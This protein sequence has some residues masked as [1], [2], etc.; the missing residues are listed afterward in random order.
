M[1]EK[2]C[3]IQLP[4]SVSAD[5]IGLPTSGA[6]IDQAIFMR[7]GE[8]YPDLP[9]GQPGPVAKTDHFCLYGSIHPFDPTAQDIHFMVGLP[10][11]WNGKAMQIGG[12]GLDGYVPL[13]CG[14]GMSAD[15]PGEMDA[16]GRGYAVFGSDSG[17][18]LDQLFPVDCS[19]GLNEEM[20][21]NFGW[22][23]LKKTYDVAMCV[24]NAWY[25]KKPEKVY[26]CGGSNGGREAFKILQ[27]SPEDYDGA[28]ILFP[29][30]K[31]LTQMIAANE[32]VKTL[33]RLG[34]DAVISDE[35]AMRIMK[36]VTDVLDGEDGLKDGIVSLTKLSA[37]QQTKVESV[38]STFLNDKQLALLR[39]FSEDFVMPYPVNQGNG[40]S[41]GFQVLMGADPRTQLGYAKHEKDN[42]VSAVA[43]NMVSCFVLKDPEADPLA[44][45]V[46][47]D[48]DAILRAAEII[49]ADN[50]NMDAW[51]AKRGKIILLHGNLDPLVPMNGTI[52]YVKALESRYG[53]ALKDHLAFYLVPGY[54][55]GDGHFKMYAPLMEQLENWVEKD[56]RPGEILATDVNPAT[57]GRTRPLYEYPYIPV[58]QGKGD[59][60]KAES[61]GKK[62]LPE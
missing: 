4:F 53:A 47:K 45:D 5:E 15:L 8:A 50:P 58:Y 56:I 12:G 6:I 51:F 32:T 39:V 28:I 23:A 38:L 21:E 2:E 57:F 61:F 46:E 48:K 62:K 36:M 43:K 17:H 42:Y 34:P 54:G 41:N 33:D 55:H 18:T 7:A 14:I 30:I 49:Q 11:C 25:G 37:A 26:F 59:P 44:L 10:V 1:N 16:M 52:Q 13:A 19:W 24:I 40:I 9:T 29:V 35:D 3:K 27:Q 60:D 31:F 22:K 20:L